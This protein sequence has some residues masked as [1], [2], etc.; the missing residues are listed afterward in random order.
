MLFLYSFGDFPVYALKVRLK[1]DEELKP[2]FSAVSSMDKSDISNILF[3]FLIQIRFLYSI[4]VMPV[5]FLNAVKKRDGERF[6]IAESSLI[7]MF[8]V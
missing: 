2:S 8:L 4:G 6:E 5:S 7:V 3:A 1:Y